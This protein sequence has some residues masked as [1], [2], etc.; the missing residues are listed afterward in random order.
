MTELVTGIDL[1]ELMLRVSAGQPIPAE[2]LAVDWSDPASM[3]GWAIESRVYAEDPTKDFL[4]SV[5]L[6]TK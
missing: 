1:V 2:L 6:L 4:P 3:K 5:G